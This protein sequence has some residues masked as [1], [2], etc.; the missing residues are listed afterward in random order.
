[1]NTGCVDEDDLAFS[2]SKHAV[3]SGTSCLGFIGDYCDLLADD[4]I[5]Q[6]RLA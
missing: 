4:A 3:N 1:M 6:S 5:Y 2:S